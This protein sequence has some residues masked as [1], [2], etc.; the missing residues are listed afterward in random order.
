MLHSAEVLSLIICDQLR[1]QAN[2]DEG[3]HGASPDC[4]CPSKS[5]VRAVN[6]ELI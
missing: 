5:K 4:L 1:H 2:V 3:Y 6:Y